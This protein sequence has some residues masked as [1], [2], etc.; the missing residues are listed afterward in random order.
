[1][2]AHARVVL[3]PWAATAPSEPVRL[4]PAPRPRQ[5]VLGPRV[6]V[7]HTRPPA[8]VGWRLLG[9]NNRELGRGV[10]ASV[11]EEAALVAVERA[12]SGLARGVRRIGHAAGVGW[13][14]RLLVDDEWL[15]ASS[16]SYQRQREC[17]YSVEQFCEWFPTAVTVLPVVRRHRHSAR[18]ETR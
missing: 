7:W 5:P 11:D 9:A 15:V 4:T 8:L 12:R 18:A 17:T 2:P 10:G 13:S 14:W 3:F 6:G 16:R 1:M